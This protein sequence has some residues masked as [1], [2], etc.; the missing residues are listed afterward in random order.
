MDLTKCLRIGSLFLTLTLWASCDLDLTKE[1]GHLKPFGTGGVNRPVE[2]IDGFPDPEYFFENYVKPTKPLKMKGAARISKAMGK[3]SDEY[4]LSL[5]DALDTEVKLETKKKEN[6][7]QAVDMMT[8]K[9]FVRIYNQTEH[10]M[11]DSVPPAL[12]GDITIPCPLQCKQLAEHNFVDNIMWF[13]SG[14]TKSVVHTDSVDNINCLYRGEKTLYFVDPSV[15]RHDVLIDHPEGAYSGMDVDAVDYTKYPGMAKVE[16]YHVNVSAG[17]CLYIPYL[18]VH[19]VRSYDS[20]L[21]VNVWW[22]R[23][24]KDDL[25]YSACNRQCNTEYT[26]AQAKFMGLETIQ[27]DPNEVRDY[28]MTYISNDTDLE[29]FIQILVADDYDKIVNDT[30]YVRDFTEMFE[31]LDADKDGLLSLTDIKALDNE[32][33]RAIGDLLELVMQDMEE[34]F[35]ASHIDIDPDLDPDHG[36]AGDSDEMDLHDEL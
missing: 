14:G 15:H 34:E 35:E 21:A 8:F 5:D 36:A 28:F 4:F 20:N 33:W 29:G 7:L 32:A 18:W 27:H 6:R 13:S 12:R 24:A 23:Y 11:V 9:N 25:D 26:M 16:F 2:E 10:Y 3:W 30:T 19:Q 22:H 31:M 1:P 17:D